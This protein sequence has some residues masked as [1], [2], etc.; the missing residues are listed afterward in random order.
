M[1]PISRSSTELSDRRQVWQTETFASTHLSKRA[2][3]NPL[4]YV[5]LPI[6]KNWNKWAPALDK[7]NGYARAISIIL[8]A[9]GLAITLDAHKW[10]LPRWPWAKDGLSN[11]KPS[12]VHPNE[13]VSVDDL[14]EMK[15]MEML[16]EMKKHEGTE[17][18]PWEQETSAD[19]QDAEG[20]NIEEAEENFMEDAEAGVGDV[21][22][23]IE[24][25]NLL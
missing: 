2:N 16:K 11:P 7:Y 23:E 3:W 13:Q 10:K 19:V 21:V 14:A 18:V 4:H 17:D 8:G 12:F 20:G 22:K 9:V 6:K 24:E 25:G 1:P 5:T 15:L